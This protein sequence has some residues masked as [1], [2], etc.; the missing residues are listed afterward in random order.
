MLVGTVRG[1]DH[2]SLDE[3][4]GDGDITLQ[5]RM[6]RLA[7]NYKRGNERHSR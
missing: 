3:Q 6:A 7:G 2:V 5:A 1:I 4:P